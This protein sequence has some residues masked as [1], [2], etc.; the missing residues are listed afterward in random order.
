VTSPM[1]F[2]DSLSSIWLDDL[3]VYPLRD[4]TKE[5]L[6]QESSQSFW[7]HGHKPVVCFTVSLT[8]YG[9]TVASDYQP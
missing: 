4:L 3:V 5:N 1:Q 2:W 9:K 8:I 7:R 6:L